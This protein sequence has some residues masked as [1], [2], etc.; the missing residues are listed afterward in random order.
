[1]TA[2]AAPPTAEVGIE[3]YTRGSLP[4]ALSGH[5]LV[6]ANRRAK[7]RSRFSRWHDSQ[8]DL[9]RLDLRPGTATPVTARVLPVDSSAPGLPPVGRD[10]LRAT[11]ASPYGYRVQPNH[12]LNLAGDTVWATNLL[13]GGALAVDIERWSPTAVL[14]H[15]GCS[16]TRGMSCTSHFAFS[17]DGRQAYLH[18][19]L[20][21]GSDPV[22]ATDLQLVELDVATGR[23]R[24]WPIDPPADDVDPAGANFH[25][26]FCFQEGGRRRVGLLRTGAVTAGQ[27]AHPDATEHQ[28][29]PARA[30]DVWL[31]DVDPGAARLQ[32]ERLPGIRELD[33]LA[34]SHLD[35]DARGDDGFVLY[36]NYKEADVG[37]ETHGVNCYGEPPAAVAEHY[38]G[39][40]I[41]ALGPG[42]VIRYERRSGE[43]VSLRSV[44]RP[45]DPMTTSA[46]HTWLPINIQLA[47]A[48]NRLYC[49]FS[50]FRPRLLPRHV[51][52]AYPDRLAD[53]ASMRFVPSAIMRLR[54]DTLEPDA[55]AGRG[56]GHIA[57]AE[58]VA[59][60]LAGDDQ[61]LCT[62]SPAIGLRIYDAHDLGRLVA[63]AEAPDLV[64]W[65]DSHF[66][67][68][69]AHL[70]FVPR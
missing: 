36:A 1:M 10:H 18:Q 3:L 39:M 31:V 54:A 38:S 21:A 67:P 37:E 55:D 28:V 11:P 34:L 62:F 32:A 14:E 25:S 47:P 17:P 68:D 59:M 9:I 61:F 15:P 27:A 20:L 63:R 2:A 51:A 44:T 53:M 12:G 66:R 7:D 46:G 13:F 24:R 23:T 45:Y 4:A 48:D 35:V 22:R 33:G 26:A 49:S 43:L 57:Y 52:A 60:T 42:R 40:I 29:L 5:L 50:G 58:P 69:P 8:A 56:R 19:S 65:G 41:D 70:V 16:P 6:A 30:S 64:H